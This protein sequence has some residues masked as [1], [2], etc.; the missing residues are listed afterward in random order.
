[1]KPLI[2]ANWKCNPQKKA[3]ALRLFDGI[4]KKVQKN[5]E[6]VICP[7]Y[8]FLFSLSLKKTKITLGAQDC[9][10]EEKGAYTGTVSAGMLKDLHC[11]Y[12][13]IGHPERRRYFSETNEI[14][15]KKIHIVLQNNLKP[16][17]CIGETREERQEGK[18]EAILSSQI[19]EG[20]RGISKSKLTH[21]VVAYEPVWAVGTGEAC[22]VS[23]TH[24][25]RLVIKRELGKMNSLSNRILYGGSVKGNNSA[26]Y[27]K[28]AG[29]QGLLVG[30]ASLDPIE[31]GKIIESAI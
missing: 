1:M 28:E 16:I 15:N 22:D 25:M 26:E 17:F 4:N 31:F 24:T 14:I 19:R 3:E 30:G 6:T 18:A 8:P 9:F 13:I 7:P 29:F 5:V 10:W 23:E 12:I 2:V 27:I 20:L 11:S 21:I